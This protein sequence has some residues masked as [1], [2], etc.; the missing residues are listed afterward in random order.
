MFVYNNIDVNIYKYLLISTVNGIAFG[1][2]ESLRIANLRSRFVSARPKYTYLM[3]K[4]NTMRVA[5][6]VGKL[7]DQMNQSPNQSIHRRKTLVRV[8]CDRPPAATKI[9]RISIPYLDEYKY[10]CVRVFDID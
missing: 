7:C 2:I 10:R 9:S 3:I 8:V 5:H 4:I 1:L 6:G